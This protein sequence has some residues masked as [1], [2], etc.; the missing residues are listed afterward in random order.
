MARDEL[1]KKLNKLKHIQVYNS[2]YKM[3]QEGVYP[4]GMQLP[5]E[6]ELAEKLNVSR[7]TLRKSLALLQEDHLIKNI[8][9]K[10]NFI[11]EL[12]ETPYENRY[13]KKKHPIWACL[14]SAITDVE[15][16]FRLEVPS[17]AIT[18]SIQQETPVV[19]IADRWYHTAEGTLAYSL[20]FVPIEVISE[21]NIS[22]HDTDPLLHFLEKQIYQER[23]SSH[24]QSH[25]GYTT[26]GNFSSTKYT[27]SD[28]GQ[29]ILIQENIFN[30]EQLLVC[31]KHYLPIEH[32]DLFIT[33]Q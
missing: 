10:G 21:A 20:S 14:D 32:F 5:S 8:R 24:S 3:I 28:N 9:G 31:N 17:D 26:S 25:F 7:S 23:V 1:N 6:P 22:L 29:F 12:P 13:E 15:L 19:V 4:P 2:I 11:L 18:T 30:Q 33:S 16:E 27:L